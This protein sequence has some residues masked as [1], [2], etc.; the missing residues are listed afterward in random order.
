MRRVRRSCRGLVGLTIP[1]QRGLLPG[2]T[3][4]A[5]FGLRPA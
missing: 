2:T 3:P 4:F 5:G 1:V